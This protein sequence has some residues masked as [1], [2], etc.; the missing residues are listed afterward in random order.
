M[1]N[2]VNHLTNLTSLLHLAVEVINQ[3]PETII[4][5]YNDGIKNE[6]N[7]CGSGILTKRNSKKQK[8]VQK[9][10]VLKNPSKLK[11]GLGIIAVTLRKYLLTLTKIRAL[12]PHK[13]EKVDLGFTRQTQNEPH[14][15][16]EYHEEEFFRCVIS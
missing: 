14:H 10:L 6:R 3:I 12:W 9:D 5:I 7:F 4:Q 1:S 8:M 2:K 11:C 16:S 13:A 15:S